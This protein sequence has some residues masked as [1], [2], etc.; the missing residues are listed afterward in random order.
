MASVLVD[1]N[2]LLDVL[3]EDPTWVDWSSDTLGRLG[4]SSLLVMNPIIYAEISISF[5]STF[6]LL[7]PMK[8]PSKEK[9]TL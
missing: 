8:L 4:R 7:Q 6:V 9:Q 3:Q 1:S 5:P 2:V